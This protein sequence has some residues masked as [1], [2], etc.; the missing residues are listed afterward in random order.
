MRTRCRGV[1]DKGDERT[2]GK[3]KIQEMFNVFGIISRMKTKKPPLIVDPEDI[4][5][6]DA[7]SREKSCEDLAGF[8][9][10]ADTPYVLAVDAPWGA[11]KTV[12]ARMLQAVCQKRGMTTVFFNAWEAD[13]HDD[14][15]AAMIGE[16][17]GKLTA[18]DEFKAVLD[19]GK[20]LMSSQMA[21]TAL[22]TI[23]HAF[24]AGTLVEGFEKALEKFDV[25]EAYRKRR[26]ALQAFKAA[27]ADYAVKNNGTL[28]FFVDE[29]DRCR[30]IFAVEV[31]EKIKHIF[32]AEGVFFVVSVNKAQLGKTIKSVYG[33]IDE[34]A[35]LRKFFDRDYP[36]V[37]RKGF[38]ASVLEYLGFVEHLKRRR[39]LFRQ[40]GFSPYNIN[41]EGEINLMAALCDAFGLSLRDCEQVAQRV[42]GAM[43]NLDNKKHIFPGITGLF[44]A[45]AVAD[46]QRFAEYQRIVANMRGNEDELARFPLADLAAYYKKAVGRDFEDGKTEEDHFLQWPYAW[47]CASRYRVDEE[48]QKK[49]DDI[50]DASHITSPFFSKIRKHAKE[51]LKCDGF[52]YDGVA[53]HPK[54]VIEALARTGKRQFDVD[55]AKS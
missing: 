10:E 7:L 30:P 31:L 4:F 8:I 43:M 20:V 16:I 28:V 24:G 25:A 34:K 26:A 15:L 46:P 2:G 14:A 38:I 13:F 40:E 11:G 45:I 32:D 48:Y 1:N 53:P 18:G 19:A 5:K 54:W 37:N 33:D 39:E 9:A 36:L 55:D 42:A 47:C 22:K 27:L 6:G 12:F 41:P 49:V 51:P 35:Y 17:S 3:L 29:L 52:F 44:A 23:G 50:V 21:M